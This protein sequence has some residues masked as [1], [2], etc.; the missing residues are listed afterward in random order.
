MSAEVSTTI[1]E[2][3]SE[4]LGL[5]GADLGVTDWVPVTQSQVELFT[6]LASKRSYW[7]LTSLD[8][9]D[10]EVWSSR[11]SFGDAD[12]EL[13]GSGNRNVPSE[14]VTQT[15]SILALS[16]YETDWIL[17]PA[18]QADQA[19]AAWRRRGHELI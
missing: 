7:R 3:P 12:G 9:F 17:V 6:V 2:A 13:A 1:V 11:G 10:G 15:Y 18:D 14:P 8:I 16:T 4:L 5:D 19:A